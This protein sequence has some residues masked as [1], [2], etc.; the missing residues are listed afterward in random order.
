MRTVV[1]A[2]CIHHGVGGGTAANSAAGLLPCIGVEIIASR[3]ATTLT[4]RDDVRVGARRENFHFALETRE[5][6]WISGEER[7]QDFGRVP[8][9]SNMAYSMLAD[10]RNDGG[11]RRVA[12]NVARALHSRSAHASRFDSASCWCGRIYQS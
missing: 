8:A 3:T 9:T 4:C 1:E 6:R 7:G 10:L 5:G 2:R 12:H 11:A